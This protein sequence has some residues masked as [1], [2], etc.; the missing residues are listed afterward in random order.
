[1]VESR[2][3]RGVQVCA[4]GI[5]EWRADR[6]KESIAEGREY[7][8]AQAWAEGW[9]QWWREGSAKGVLIHRCH[10]F[11]CLQIMLTIT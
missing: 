2:E 6:M 7:G 5:E 10:Q 11:Y 9:A 8:R 3:F 1:M 4:L